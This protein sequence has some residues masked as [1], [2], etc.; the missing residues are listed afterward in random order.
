MLARNRLDSLN[1]KAF[2]RE[3]EV[4]RFNQWFGYFFLC[5]NLPKNIKMLTIF[6]KIIDTFVKMTTS[7]GSIAGC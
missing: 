4:P 3:V 7:K 1:D 2:I 6:T 5:W